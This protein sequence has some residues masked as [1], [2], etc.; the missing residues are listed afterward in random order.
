M[1]NLSATCSTAPQSKVYRSRTARESPL[2]QCLSAHFYD[3]VQNYPDTFEATHGFFRPVVEDAV[4][5]FIDCGDLR[6]GFAVAQCGECGERFLVAFSCKRRYLCPSCHQK[7]VLLFG[8]FIMNDVVFPV[9]H[10][11]HVFTIPKM[12]RVYFRNDRKLLGKLAKVAQDCLVQ[13]MRTTLNLPDGKVGIVMA[14]QTFG[15]FLK[16]FHPHLHTLVADGLFRNSGTFYVMPEVDLQPLEEMFRARII[17]MLQDQELLSDELAEKLYSWKHSGFSVHAGDPIKPDQ[18]LALERT[19]RY[20]IRNTFSLKKMTYNEETNTV[21]YKTDKIHPKTKR[22]FE[23]FTTH[24]FIA[25]ITQ[26]I[27]DKGAQMVR[28]YGWYSNRLRGRRRMD[29]ESLA[30]PPEGI[31]VIDVSDYSP[32]KIPS[33]KWRQLIAKVWEVDPLVCP[34]C[35]SIML[36][37]SLTDDPFEAKKALKELDLWDDLVATEAPSRS[38]PQE[39]ASSITLDRTES[40]LPLVDVFWN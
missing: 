4:N 13:F 31:E 32:P 17:R 5:Q 10:R 15:E 1:G 34:R 20:I 14:I 18:K 9:P 3:F 12:L 19:A 24:E 36:I 11:Q 40:Q 39:A 2:W 33:K 23:V 27:P 6:K 22:N 28:Y 25:A 35:G 38:P 26:H 8:D 30:S 37:R 29:Q 21:L 16:N 7:K